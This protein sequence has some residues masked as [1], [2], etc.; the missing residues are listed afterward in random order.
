A[1]T[2]LVRGG[3]FP[4]AP[5]RPNLAVDIGLLEFVRVLFL[6]I[7]PNVKAWCKASEIYLL[8]RGHKI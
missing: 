2:Q 4:C 6:H 5:Y 3:L 1:A 7:S 8:G